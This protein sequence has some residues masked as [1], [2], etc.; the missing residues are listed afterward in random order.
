MYLELFKKKS[1]VT[2]L[3]SYFQIPK[4]KIDYKR[5]ENILWYLI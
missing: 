5:R 1:F 3:H 2:I 4:I